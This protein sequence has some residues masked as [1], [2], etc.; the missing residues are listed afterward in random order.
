[1][2]KNRIKKKV[3]LSLSSTILLVGGG[4]PRSTR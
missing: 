1:M 4:V 3:W 2:K